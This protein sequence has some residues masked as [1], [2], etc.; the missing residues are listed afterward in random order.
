MIRI[1]QSSNRSEVES[2]LKPTLIRDRATET[3]AQKI[4]DHVR[5]GGDEALKAYT[6]ALDGWAGPLEVRLLKEAPT[7]LANDDVFVRGLVDASEQTL[8]PV[9]DGGRIG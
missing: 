9:R 5:N 7:E 2:L 8:E 4:V 6:K 1:V 3:Q